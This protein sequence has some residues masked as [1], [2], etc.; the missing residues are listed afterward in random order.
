M[1][2]Y[3]FFSF[4]YTFYKFFLTQ[5]FLFLF[6]SFDIIYPSKL[7]KEIDLL[8]D[9]IAKENLYIKRNFIKK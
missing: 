3:L 5:P 9:T 4:E 7:L 6:L 2:N 1:F 8:I